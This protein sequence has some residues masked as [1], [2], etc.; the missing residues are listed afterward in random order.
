MATAR[1][2]ASFE[3]A[4]G[5]DYQIT[6]TIQTSDLDTTPVDITG[7]T[8]NITVKRNPWDATASV[9]TPTITIV[10]AASGSVKAVFAAADTLLLNGDYVYDFWRTNAGAASLLC[11]GVFSVRDTGKN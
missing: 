5:E 8:F 2:S 4:R 10:T 7:W 11:D 9:I 6:W 3:C 1:A